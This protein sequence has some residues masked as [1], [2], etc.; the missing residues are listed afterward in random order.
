MA[1]ICLLLLNI[2]GA[3]SANDR[4]PDGLPDVQENVTDLRLQDF[5]FVLKLL[6]LCVD[7]HLVQPLPFSGAPG[8]V[9]PRGAD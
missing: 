6:D 2:C 4:A 3:G 8:S 7:F 5:D 1:P 9:R